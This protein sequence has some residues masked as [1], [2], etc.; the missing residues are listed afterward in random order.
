MGGNDNITHRVLFRDAL[1]TR[2]NNQR[3]MH[4]R[5]AT[6]SNDDRLGGVQR[7]PTNNA[8][9]F[10]QFKPAILKAISCIPAVG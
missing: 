4:R 10:I 7:G 1:G 6:E 5:I 9:P 8:L 3:H 2:S